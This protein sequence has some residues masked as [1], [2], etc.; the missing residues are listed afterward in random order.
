L[1]GVLERLCRELRRQQRVC[2]RLTLTVRYSDH[3]EVTRRQR[4]DAGTAWEAEL[5]P[6]VTTLFARCVRRRV[7]VRMMTVGAEALTPP[8]GQL[9]LFDEESPPTLPSLSQ[10]GGLWSGG[11][12]EQKNSAR[13]R[14]LALALDRVRDRF[15]DAAIRCGSFKL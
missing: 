9:L 3:V 15:G 12:A 14:R 11:F 10:G 13:A 1:Y 6:T 2:R 4:L 7:R 5:S 8:E